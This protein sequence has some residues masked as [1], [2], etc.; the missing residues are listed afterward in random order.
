MW[1]YFGFQSVRTRCVCASRI[2]ATYVCAERCL[3]RPV[4]THARL[5][6]KPFLNKGVPCLLT[7]HSVPYVLPYPALGLFHEGGEAEC[8]N[9]G[10]CPHEHPVQL[11][12]VYFVF[13][14]VCSLRIYCCILLHTAAY[15]TAA[16]CFCFNHSGGRFNLHH[17]PRQH[18]V[19]RF[20]YL[21]CQHGPRCEYSI[22]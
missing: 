17:E 4:Y 8:T 1:P 12:P 6:V 11:T 3:F 15:H 19:R 2:V 21:H 22:L 7:L 13:V 18:V 14:P 16:A 10:W 9:A 5:V 20:R